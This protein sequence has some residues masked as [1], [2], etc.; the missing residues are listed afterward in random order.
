VA[1]A[2]I[3]ARRGALPQAER[4]LREV[5]GRH[6]RDEDVRAALFDV[7]SWQ[8][9][10]DEAA[11]LLDEAPQPEGG[12]VLARRARLAYVR[13]DATRARELGEHAVAR[14]NGDRDVRELVEAITTGQARITTRRLFYPSGW[15]DLMQV[16]LAVAQAFGRLVLGAATEQGQRPAATSGGRAYGATYGASATWLFGYGYAAGVEAAFGAPAESVPRA[17]VR[18]TATAPLLRW[19]SLG[20]AYTFR[21]YTDGAAVHTLSPSLSLSLAGELSIDATYWLTHVGTG[22]EGPS[23][24]LSSFGL[25]ASRQMLPWLALRAGYAHGAESE[26]SPA[27]F[28]LLDLVADSGFVGAELAVTRA[29]R[30]YPLYGLT[31]RGKRGAERIP[32]HMLELGA[33]VRF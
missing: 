29:F 10:W 33:G 30:L 27:A 22:P 28:Q 2:R 17:R 1:L 9:R 13:G 18:V 6:P 14:S 21:S 32:V 11:R 5:L 24:W 26:R 25:S 16:D 3:D 23:R 8:G 7:L 20:A 31:L 12:P 15:P 4:A 19:L